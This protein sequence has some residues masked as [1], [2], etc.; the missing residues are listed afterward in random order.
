MMLLQELEDA[1]EAERKTHPDGPEEDEVMAALQKAGRD[2]LVRQVLHADDHHKASYGW[3]TRHARY[4]EK[5]FGALGFDLSI[6]RLYGYVHLRPGEIATGMRRGRIRKDETVVLFALRTLWEEGSRGG[7]MDDYG[8]I[9]IDTD[10]V[11]DRY[12][13]MGGGEIP[14][15]TRLKQI[16]EGLADRGFLRLGEED[17][18][19]EIHPVSVMPVIR[20]LVTPELAAEVERYLAGSSG[21][22]DVLEHL[23]AARE[24]EPVGGAGGDAPDGDAPDRGAPDRGAPDRG[25]PDGEGT[26]TMLKA[27][28]AAAEDR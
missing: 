1:I 3:I 6:D 13:T 26:A 10:A 24:A 25:A 28:P 11:L 27:A 8:R 16:L 15:K 4:F 18:V 20:E 2:L 23:S 12:V 17:P 22:G 5:L 19:E 7:E 14:T 21:E 9:E